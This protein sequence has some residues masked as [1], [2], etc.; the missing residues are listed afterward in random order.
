MLNKVKRA[1][2]RVFRR[3]P[4]VNIEVRDLDLADEAD[5]R[6]ACALIGA[7]EAAGLRDAERRPAAPAAPAVMVLED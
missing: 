3:K 2:K 5:F 6:L 7:V 4:E 1:M